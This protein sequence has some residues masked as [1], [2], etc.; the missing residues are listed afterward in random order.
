MRWYTLN[1]PSVVHFDRPFKLNGE[2]AHGRLRR[3]AH[4][5]KMILGV[6]VARTIKAQ[7]SPDPIKREFDRPDPKC[8]CKFE[9]AGATIKQYCC[10]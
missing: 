3:Y 2:H 4:E 9:A 1:R 10:E 7:E 6:V 8:P 5:D